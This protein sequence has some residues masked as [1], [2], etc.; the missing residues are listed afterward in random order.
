[1]K[2]SEKL[3]KY[4]GQPSADLD[5]LL[6]E[7]EQLEDAISRH[8]TYAPDLLGYHMDA[9]IYNDKILPLLVQPTHDSDAV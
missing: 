3:R 2:P 1:M 7:V 6:L 9:R 8:L 5:R 4:F